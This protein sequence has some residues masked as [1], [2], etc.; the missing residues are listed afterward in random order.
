MS[1]VVEV[2]TV[3]VCSRSR[4]VVDGLFEVLDHPRLRG[5][6]PDLWRAQP[7]VGAVGSGDVESRIVE[8]RASLAIHEHGLPPDAPQQWSV[9]VSSERES[10]E[11]AVYA[12]P[13][14][15]CSLDQAGEGVEP[16]R[17]QDLAIGAVVGVEGGEPAPSRP[18]HLNEEV[19]GPEL[20]GRP[21]ELLDPVGVLEGA[22]GS[23]GQHPQTQARRVPLGRVPSPDL[24]G[25][26]RK[27]EEAQGKEQPDH[28]G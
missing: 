13:T 28:C 10:V 19:G 14:G 2:E 20:F 3:E 8:E 4:E 18:V 22:M 6:Q 9:P 7:R 24:A 21:D 25:T 1:D 26:S 27:E 23:L 11:P 12:E 16:L 17:F 5:V 15:V